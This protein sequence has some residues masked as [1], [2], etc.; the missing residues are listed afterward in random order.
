M[1]AYSIPFMWKRS[2]NRLALFATMSILVCL[3]PGIGA[4]SAEKMVN[5]TLMSEDEAIQLGE[6]FGLIVGEVDEELRDFLGL[7]QAE[8][9]VVFEVIG[10]KPA[11]LA[12]VKAKSIIK[13][14]DSH[15]IRNLEDFGTALKHAIG[16]ENFSLV[17]YE[18]ADPANQGITGGVQFHF[19]RIEK[20]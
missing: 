16:T 14:I 9:V 8:G 19:V 3:L 15:E 12:G 4:H 2:C 17:T 11:D 10:G 5:A 6:E 7:Q 20:A 1:K 18:P 13:E